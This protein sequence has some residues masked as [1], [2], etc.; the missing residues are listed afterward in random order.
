MTTHGTAWP[1]GREHLARREASAAKGVMGGF[2]PE[3]L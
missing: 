1:M 2:P 3:S